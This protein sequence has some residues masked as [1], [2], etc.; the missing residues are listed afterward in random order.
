[1]AARLCLFLRNVAGD[2]LRGDMD[3]KQTV[4]PEQKVKAILEGLEDANLK[5]L[6]SL[7]ACA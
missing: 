5:G 6:R 4:E 2:P 1:M 3:E 7:H